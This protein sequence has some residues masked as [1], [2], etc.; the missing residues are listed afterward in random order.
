MFKMFTNTMVNEFYIFMANTYNE[1]H[2]NPINKIK[3]Q[4]F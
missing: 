1:Y 3:K 4:A 2:K